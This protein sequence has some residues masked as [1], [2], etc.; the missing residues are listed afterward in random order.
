MLPP[1]IARALRIYDTFPSFGSR[2][3]ADVD[4]RVCVSAQG[5]V[6]DA[7]V[8]DRQSGAFSDTLRAAI[9]SWRYRPL[10]VNGLPT[11]FCHLM[12]ISYRTS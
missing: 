9:L 5:A 2:T 4:V 7:S 6:S 3:G 1:N 12:H 10:M 11:P 8:D